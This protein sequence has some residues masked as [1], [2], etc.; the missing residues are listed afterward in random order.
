[1]ILICAC[2]HKGHVERALNVYF[3]QGLPS[4]FTSSSS[5]SKET[6]IDIDND[7]DNDGD[8][9]NDTNN[10]KDNND[11]DNDTDNDGLYFI[12]R[13]NVEAYTLQKGFLRL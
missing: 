13:R 8:S 10:D 1:M 3:D 12:G 9:D 5:R 7:N 6:D 2:D 11:N 4:P